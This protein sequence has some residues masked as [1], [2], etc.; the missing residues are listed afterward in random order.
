VKYY[1]VRNTTP[2]FLT[3]SD[4]LNDAARCRWE[5]RGY[6]RMPNSEVME[7][8]LREIAVFPAHK[9]AVVTILSNEDTEMGIVC[10]KGLRTGVQGS[11]VVR[12]VQ[13]PRHIW[14]QI[15]RPEL[16]DDEIDTA[17]SV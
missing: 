16:I 12:E 2:D 17:D 15:E 9:D 1:L 10:D 13:S 5:I 4:L 8:V 14:T 7:R 3:M 11:F 6:G